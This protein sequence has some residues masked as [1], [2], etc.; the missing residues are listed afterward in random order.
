MR[1]T[2]RQK[3]KACRQPPDW[4]SRKSSAGIRQLLTFRLRPRTVNMRSPHLS[5]SPEYGNYTENA[6]DPWSNPE[7]PCKEIS[8]ALY[9]TLFARKRRSGDV[10]I[11]RFLRGHLPDRQRQRSRRRLP[12]DV[13]R[14]PCENL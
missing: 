13:A 9:A 11:R 10:C 1:R 12:A 6:E 7:K 5:T 4:S 2:A 8:P 14:L 3:A